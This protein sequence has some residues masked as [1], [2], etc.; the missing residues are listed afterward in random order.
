MLYLDIDKIPKIEYAKNFAYQVG[1][2]LSDILFAYSIEIR[3]RYLT[4][5]FAPH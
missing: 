4:E 3:D 5:K 1:C 2:P